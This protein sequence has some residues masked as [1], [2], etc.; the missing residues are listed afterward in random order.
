MDSIFSVREVM[1]V[2][3]PCWASANVDNFEL[4]EAWAATKESILPSRAVNRSSRAAQRAIRED[5]D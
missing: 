4:V 3:T 2:R 1:A 5:T